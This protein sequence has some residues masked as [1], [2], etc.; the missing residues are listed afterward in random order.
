M[1]WIIWRISKIL[2]NFLNFFHN[3]LEYWRL[4]IFSHL[5][6]KF[7]KK[8]IKIWMKNSVFKQNFVKF[9]MNNY[10]KSP[11]LG[12]VF[13]WNFEVW[14]V[15][16]NV[17]LVDLE[18]CWKMSIWSQ[19]SASIQPRTSLPKFLWNGG[20][21]QELHPSCKSVVP[22]RNVLPADCGCTPVLLSAARILASGVGKH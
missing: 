12:R 15:Q 16:R 18:K 21:K 2:R 4:L 8:F 19:K 10:S 14:A 11:K 6:V 20:P 17:N 22:F 9:W 13:C 5:F 3:F 1:Y 7:R